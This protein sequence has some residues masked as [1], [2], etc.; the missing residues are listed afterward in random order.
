MKHRTSKLSGIFGAFIVMLILSFPMNAEEHAKDTASK[1]VREQ[2]EALWSKMGVGVA[3][4]EPWTYQEL[5]QKLEPW[6]YRF[7]VASMFEGVV[8]NG[9]YTHGLGCFFDHEPGDTNQVSPEELLEI[10]R[11]IGATNM[12]AAIEAGRAELKKT[13]LKRY[14]EMDEEQCKKLDAI[15][16]GIY[17]FDKMDKDWNMLLYAYM[18][19]YGSAPN[20]RS[21]NKSD[22]KK[23]AEK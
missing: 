19:K 3:G 13:G 7:L 21:V 6:E 4:F 17:G 11:D 22:L 9:G 14:E 12:I 2:Y 5:R 20:A 23:E 18:Q 1:A 16:E 15:A 10:L 8:G